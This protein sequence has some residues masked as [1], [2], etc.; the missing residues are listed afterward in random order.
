VLA[1]AST[2]SPHWLQNG[3]RE[4]AGVLPNAQH[5]ELDGGFHEPR[6]DLVAAQL[7]SSFLP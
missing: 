1:L 5:L 3:A 6:P 7:R 2:A 4:V